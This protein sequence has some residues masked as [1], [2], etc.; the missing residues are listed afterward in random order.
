MITAV[1]GSIMLILYYS[2]GSSS[3]A[4]HIALH[5]QRA[6]GHRCL[7]VERQVVRPAGPADAGSQP[8]LYNR[9]HTE[10]HTAHFSERSRMRLADAPPELA[11]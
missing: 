9:R 5:E 7:S 11:A 2:P 6:A 3:M 1:V 4:A 10:R 8:R